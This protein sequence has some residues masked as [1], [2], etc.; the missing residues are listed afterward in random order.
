M[1]ECRSSWVWRLDVLWA[2][3]GQF[4]WSADRAI[5]VEGA[6][7]TMFIRVTVAYAEYLCVH[8]WMNWMEIAY[9]TCHWIAIQRKWS[10]YCVSLIPYFLGCGSTAYHI[11]KTRWQSPSQYVN[12]NILAQRKSTQ[13]IQLQEI[14]S[15][16]ASARNWNQG[17]TWNIWDRRT[18]A[19]FVR[20]TSE[21][22]RIIHGW[23]V[24]I[25]ICFF[26]KYVF[27][28]V[29]SFHVLPWFARPCW[30]LPAYLHLWRWKSN[31]RPGLEAHHLRSICSFDQFCPGV[32]I[33][34]CRL[35]WREKNMVWKPVEPLFWC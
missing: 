23:S 25:Y 11:F 15:S 8:V 31:V 10:T 32:I 20:Y 7:Q 4:V 21:D 3:W 9:P 18:P 27:Y 24:W 12:W 13:A 34:N 22:C 2:W 29:C 26:F 30:M 28:M 33:R 6:I 5:H 14:R 17:L 16:K 1:S 35:G 19:I